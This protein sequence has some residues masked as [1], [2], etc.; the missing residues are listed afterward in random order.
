MYN[1]I[2]LVMKGNELQYV[3]APKGSDVTVIDSESGIMFDLHEENPKKSGGLVN[4]R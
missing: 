1:Q 3:Q 2:F 4:Y